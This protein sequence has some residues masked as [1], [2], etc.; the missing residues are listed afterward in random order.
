VMQCDAACS[1]VTYV[2]VDIESF[3]PYVNES[4]HDIVSNS[5]NHVT[6]SK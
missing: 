4:S 1:G 3:A 5:A 6:L 2:Q